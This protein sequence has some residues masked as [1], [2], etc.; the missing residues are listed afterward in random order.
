MKTTP[1]IDCLMEFLSI[2][3]DSSLPVLQRFAQLDGSCP[4][5]KRGKRSFVYIPG[6]R[7]DRVV[8]VAHADTFWDWYYLSRSDGP[9]TRLMKHEPYLDGDVVLQMGDEEWGLGADDRAGCAMLWLLKD[10]GHS[11]LITDGEEHGQRAAHYIR[12]DCPDIYRELN[13][14]R[15]MIQLDRRGASD[16]KTYRIPVTGEFRRYVEEHT[17]YADAGYTSRT[18]IV[19]LCMDVAGV[20]LS[21]GYYNEHTPAEILRVNEWLHTYETVRKLLEQPQPPFPLPVPNLLYTTDLLEQ[22]EKERTREEPPEDA[23]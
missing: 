17:G 14:H 11:L 16:Y 20:N 15:Y 13:R 21:I 12:T 19:R 9:D 1:E 6:T 18:D 8:L 10:S 7:E 2:R 3:P 23:D 5:F 4:V 22:L